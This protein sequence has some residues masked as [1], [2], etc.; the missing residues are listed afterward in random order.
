M[1]LEEFVERY[2][3]EPIEDKQ[4]E[5]AKQLLWEELGETRS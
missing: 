2:E 5:M 3:F 4:L 1:P